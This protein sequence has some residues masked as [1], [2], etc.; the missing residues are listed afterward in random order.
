MSFEAFSPAQKQRIIIERD[1]LEQYF[2]GRVSW[3]GVKYVE[4]AMKSNSNR[5]YKLRV[6]I[7]EDFPNSCPDLVVVKPKNM[8]KRGGKALPSI[9]HSFHTLGKKDDYIK[10]C[11]YI[12][13]NWTGDI[14]FYQVFMKGR[15]WIEAYEGHL[16]TGRKMKSYLRN[17][18]DSD[19][20]DSSD[21]DSS[22]DDRCILM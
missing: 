8:K 4:I 5:N 1:L 2:P 15:L 9:S 18:S 13:G 19:D 6:Y 3:S 22:D 11:H 17:Q 14:T 16:N 10:I 7:A 20:D 21:D 12:P